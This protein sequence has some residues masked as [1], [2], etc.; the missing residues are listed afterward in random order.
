MLKTANAVHI[1]VA[2]TMYRPPFTGGAK[3]PATGLTNCANRSTRAHRQCVAENITELRG[4]VH[5][6]D[7]AGVNDQV[8]LVKKPE[9]AVSF[10]VNRVPKVTLIC[11]EHGDNG[12]DFMFVRSFV[13]LLANRK[14]RHRELLLESSVQLYLHKS[15]SAS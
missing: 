6:S 9:R 7:L 4:L 15:A 10:H 12:S 13:D 11:P 8:F 3:A 14:L 2:V 1:F 5:H